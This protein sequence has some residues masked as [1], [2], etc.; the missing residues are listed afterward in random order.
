M[1]RGRI[2]TIVG[3]DPAGPLYSVNDP[4]GRLDAGDAR[5]VEA[6]HTN[7]PTLLVVGAGIGAPIAHADFFANGGRSQPGCILNGCSHDRAV[8]YY[9]EGLRNNNFHALGCANANEAQNENCSIQPGAWISSEPLSN[10]VTDLRG[11]FSFSTN[12]SSPF[13][14]GPARP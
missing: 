2:D 6:I 14:R 13:G 5:Y 10:S 4:A 12:R 8:E 7:G 3:L 1:R 9:L 11:I